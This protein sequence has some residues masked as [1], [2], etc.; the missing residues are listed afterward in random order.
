MNSDDMRER[1][2]EVAALDDAVETGIAKERDE[3]RRLLERLVKFVEPAL[4]ALCSVVPMTMER[5]APPAMHASR[6]GLRVCEVPLPL[7][8]D[9]S[10]QF[11]NWLYVDD[12]GRFFG[13]RVRGEPSTNAGRVGDHGHGWAWFQATYVDLTTEDVI[14]SRWPV[15]DI[16]EA[17]AK[18]LESQTRGLEKKE[19][20]VMKTTRLVRAVADLLSEVR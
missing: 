12:S 8:S 14:E 1:A 15:S 6:R 2:L 7:E 10:T 17:L 9:G 3:K 11:W 18:A 5:G 4:P 16:A 20:S 13:A 19:R